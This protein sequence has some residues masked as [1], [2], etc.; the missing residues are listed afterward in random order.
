[1]TNSPNLKNEIRSRMKT[2]GEPYVVAR[3]FV[4][5]SKGKDKPFTDI[6][7]GIP[8]DTKSRD[9]QEVAQEITYLTSGVLT[10]KVTAEERQRLPK[11]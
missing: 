5:D 10:Q 9:P 3:R 6:S 8:I 2:T 7:I 11:K 4:L 1:M